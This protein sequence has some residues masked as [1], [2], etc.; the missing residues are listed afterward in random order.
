MKYYLIFEFNFPFLQRTWPSNMI[1]RPTYHWTMEMPSCAVRLKNDRVSPVE[2]PVVVLCIDRSKAPI[3]ALLLDVCFCH[4]CLTCVQIIALATNKGPRN[5]IKNDP[6]LMQLGFSLV[7]VWKGEVRIYNSDN[8]YEVNVYADVF[9]YQL[10]CSSEPCP[11]S[12]LRKP[13]SK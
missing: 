12:M 2:I 3:Q 13:S 11:T 9:I 7:Y 10:W 4:V 5:D 8:T 1:V 6:L